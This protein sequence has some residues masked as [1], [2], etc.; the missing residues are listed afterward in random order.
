MI[1]VTAPHST[2]STR[3]NRPEGHAEERLVA[4]PW[5]ICGTCPSLPQAC[6]FA[7]WMG[8]RRW[9][10]AQRRIDCPDGITDPGGRDIC[11]KQGCWPDAQQ[12]SD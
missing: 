1:A 10:K 8:H 11:V 4:R 2:P 3:K 5:M 12:I 9:Q 7:K 6:P